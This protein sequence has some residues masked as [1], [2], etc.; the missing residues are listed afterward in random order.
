MSRVFNEQYNEF[1]IFRLGNLHSFTV[2][3]NPTSA[4]ELANKK[5]IDDALGEKSVLRFNQASE[6][7]LKVSVGKSV[8]NL[9]IIT[10]NNL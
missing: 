10:S 3:R 7:N 2:N 4:K 9:K 1:D 8:Y 5:Y 6:Q